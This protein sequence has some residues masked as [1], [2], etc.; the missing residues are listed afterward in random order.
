VLLTITGDPRQA[1]RVCARL[2]E[3]DE[4]SAEAHYVMAL[5]REHAG[6]VAAAATH[7]QY[8][9]YLDPGF[10][11]PRLHLGQLAMRA[12]ERDV[13]RR[14]FARAVVLLA[15]ED[16][17]RIL[18]LGGGFTRESLTDLCRTGLVACGGAA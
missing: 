2:L 1:E 10:A 8:A 17:A 9:L 3:V 12:G 5:C 13:A 16:G 7:D 4:L 14:E 6:D 11:M 15:A 18:L